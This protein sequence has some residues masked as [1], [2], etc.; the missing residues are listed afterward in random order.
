MQAAR[1]LFPLTQHKFV[2]TRDWHVFVFVTLSPPA[3]SKK[4]RGNS[5]TS[6]VDSFRLAWHISIMQAARQLF[7]LNALMSP[8]RILCQFVLWVSSRMVVPVPP[9]GLRVCFAALE[10][11][12]D[13]S[14]AFLVSRT[15]KGLRR[16]RLHHSTADSLVGS[17][18]P[19][20]DWS[21][22]NQ[23]EERGQVNPAVCRQ[24]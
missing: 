19:E 24:P 13:P 11:S 17:G 18:G 7:P 6:D 21:H 3:H 10:P 16:F 23:T 5:S 2:C 9:S 15:D 8:L 22:Q 4:W 12:V 20:F 14:A 1:Q